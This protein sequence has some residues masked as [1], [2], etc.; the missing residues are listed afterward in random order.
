VACKHVIEDRARFSEGRLASGR[1]SGAREM[2]LSEYRRA[3]GA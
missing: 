3:T 1:E 2:Q